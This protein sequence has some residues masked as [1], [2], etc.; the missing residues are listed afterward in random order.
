MGTFFGVPIIIRTIVFWG[1]H[2]GTL[3]F[4][5]LPYLNMLKVFVAGVGG[6]SQSAVG[7]EL[8]SEE[9]VA[10]PLELC[11]TQRAQ[12]SL[13]KEDILNLM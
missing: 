10:M 5:K 8:L 13:I 3:M 11:Y 4:W 7:A 12:H 2:W 9:K 1:V 6:Y